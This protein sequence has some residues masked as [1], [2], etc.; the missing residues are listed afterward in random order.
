MFSKVREARKVWPN[1]Y[2]RQGRERLTLVYNKE[3]YK[4]KSYK[5][6]YGYIIYC[7]NA[8]GLHTWFTEANKHGRVIAVR[9]L[10][11]FYAY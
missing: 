4:G 10:R 8:T 3:I 1:T 5:Y 6:V 7:S 11:P 9:H 2:D